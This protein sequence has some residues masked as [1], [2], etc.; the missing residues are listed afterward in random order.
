MDGVIPGNIR[1]GSLIVVGKGNP[2]ALWSSSHGTGWALGRKQA[3]HQLTLK[4]FSDSMFGIV[5]RVNP[6]TL[7][8]APAAYKNLDR[9]LALQRDLVTVL[10]RVRPLINIKG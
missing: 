3:K 1:D 6:G 7:D 2:Q 8:E 4:G 10:H 5:A 9:V